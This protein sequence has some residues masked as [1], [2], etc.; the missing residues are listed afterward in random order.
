MKTLV[1]IAVVS[2]VL[3]SG[4]AQYGG[5]RP[6]YDNVSYNSGG[7]RTISGGYISGPQV[8]GGQQQYYQQPQQRQYYQQ[9]YYA[10]QPQYYAPQQYYQPVQNVRQDEVDCQDLAANA[11]SYGT[12]VATNGVVG[13]LGGAAAGAAFGAI[14][15]DPAKGAQYGSIAAIPAALYGASTADTAYK[16]GFVT[17]MRGR[18]YNVVQ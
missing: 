3:V 18:G 5:Y 14:S 11:A 8:G 7:G 13:A 17:C 9:P 12:S 4:C 15:G 16:K 2:S 10:S 1:M 6:T